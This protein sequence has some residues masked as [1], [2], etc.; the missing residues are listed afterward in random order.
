MKLSF[1]EKRELILKYEQIVQQLVK[2]KNYFIR[3]SISN[4]ISELFIGCTDNSYIST[5][6]Q[7]YSSHEKVKE[8]LIAIQ[9]DLIDKQ[10][11]IENLLDE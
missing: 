8:I 9:Q 7:L 3:R 10:I 11:D 2:I 1:E 6:I 4:N 5:P